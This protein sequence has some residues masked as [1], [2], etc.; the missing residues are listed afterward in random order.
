[1]SEKAAAPSALRR[2]RTAA[3]AKS[4]TA[5]AAEAASLRGA[6][7][8]RFEVRDDGPG[9]SAADKAKLFAPFVQIKAGA[10]QKG[11]GTGLGLS[12]CKHIV[13]LSGGRVGASCFAQE[14]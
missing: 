8:V 11:N 7:F 3:A 4:A 12:I 2:R 14:C 13:E 1:M 6:A 5:I 10:L 9:I